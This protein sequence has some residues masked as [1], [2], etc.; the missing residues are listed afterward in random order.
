MIALSIIQYKW[1]NFANTAKHQASATTQDIAG[2][3]KW[4]IITYVHQQ[5]ALFSISC[6]ALY[7]S[8]LPWLLSSLL[9]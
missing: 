7:F 8:N 1:A 5:E 9:L 6:V 4:L 3:L 2:L